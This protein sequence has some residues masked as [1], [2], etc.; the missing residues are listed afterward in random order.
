ML[1]TAAG[2]RRLP[3][4]RTW[5][6][7][8]F[9]VHEPSALKRRKVLLVGAFN[10]GDFYGSYASPDSEVRTVDSE[11]WAAAAAAG[12][13]THNNAALEI[14]APP[15]DSAQWSRASRTDK[16][17]RRRKPTIIRSSLVH[18]LFRR[19]TQCTIWFLARYAC[20]FQLQKHLIAHPNRFVA[21]LSVSDEEVETSRHLPQ[22]VRDLNSHLPEDVQVLSAA[23]C[24]KS[25]V[26]RHALAGREYTY[27]M[28]LAALVR[29]EALS[30]QLQH[31]TSVQDP[32]LSHALVKQALAKL[33]DCTQKYTG[34][35]PWHN[36]TRHKQRSVLAR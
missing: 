32:V 18:T 15:S 28:P 2:L 34:S 13:H 23:R 8:Q 14:S 25:T 21:Q 35:H 4:S 17:V 16:G 36:F 12:R 26:A 20:G 1:L 27:F 30:E 5:A 10:G 22:L 24:A 3:C 6:H 33:G 29:D 11:L 19:C 9:S 7:R 31:I